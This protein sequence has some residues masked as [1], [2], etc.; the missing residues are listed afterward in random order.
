MNKIGIFLGTLMC[1]FWSLDY[2]LTK[3]ALELFSPIFFSSIRFFIVWVCL[4]PFLRRIP[5][6]FITL[7]WLSFPLVVL[8]YAGIDIA[9]NLNSSITAVNT[10]AQLQ[11]I[12]AIIAASIFLKEK[13]TKKQIIGMIISFIGVVIVIISNST[14]NENLFGN[15]IDNKNEI[16]IV[17]SIWL[18]F[19]KNNIKSFIILLIAIFSWPIYTTY[20]KKLTNDGVKEHEIIGWTAL[21]G[22]LFGLITSFIFEENQINSIKQAG[23]INY[24]YFLYTS[25]FGVLIP[26]ILFHYLVKISNVSKVSIIFLL[27]PFLTALGEIFFF[28]KEITLIFSI[29]GII[30]LLGILMSQ[31]FGA[32]EKKES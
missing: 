30:L 27:T 25:I 32:N 13:I 19:D 22:S 26:H 11:I 12:T 3:K 18:Y 21:F 5:P 9:I 7:I 4:I 31:Y 2:I 1:L 29:G 8:F 17:N 23:L 20:S 16:V 24:S 15:I 6:K 28:K 10:F 14:K